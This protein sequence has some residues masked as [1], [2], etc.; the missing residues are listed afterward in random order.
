MGAALGSV[1]TPYRV[2]ENL[3]VVS[4]HAI[5]ASTASVLATTPNLP[6]GQKAILSTQ[7]Q[8]LALLL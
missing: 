1:A 7:T 3:S 2:A 8:C 5:T 4:R 6:S